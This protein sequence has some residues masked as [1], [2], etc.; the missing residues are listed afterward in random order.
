MGTWEHKNI[1]KTP[2]LH[3]SLGIFYWGRSF[4]IQREIKKKV[5]MWDFWVN[6]I[7]KFII[8]KNLKIWKLL[9]L[10]G[11]L[12]QPLSQVKKYTIINPL[13][14]HALGD[15]VTNGSN[16]NLNHSIQVVVTLHNKSMIHIHNNNIFGFSIL[17]LLTPSKLSQTI[18][19]I[20]GSFLLIVYES[21]SPS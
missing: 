18:T 5:F 7:A 21:Y 9:E 10:F 13:Y 2:P 8:W 3:D 19:I 1:G 11:T 15:H 14:N 12:M 16:L 17:L 4:K 20:V 6:K